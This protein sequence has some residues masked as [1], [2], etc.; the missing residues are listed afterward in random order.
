[1]GPTNEDYTSSD[2]QKTLACLEQAAQSLTSV[3]GVET[4]ELENLGASPSVQ[5]AMLDPLVVQKRAAYFKYSGNPDLQPIWSTES[6]TLVRFLHKFSVSINQVVGMFQFPEFIYIFL[7]LLKHGPQIAEFWYRDDFYGRVARQFLA[8]PCLAYHFEKT[9]P[10]MPA[11]RVATA[12]PPRVCLRPLA[13][14]RTFYIIFFLIFVPYLMNYSFPLFHLSIFV[15]YCGYV[16]VK[17][18]IEPY[19]PKTRLQEERDF[20][21]PPDI[22]FNE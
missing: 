12:L 13:A 1:M 17:A 2:L 19:L 21:I 16:A 10:G 15:A 6:A 4:P 18:G 14:H 11:P 22:S 9:A 20:F 7:L 3:F 5:P 8:A